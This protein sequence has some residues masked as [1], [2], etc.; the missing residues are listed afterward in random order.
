MKISAV[1]DIPSE[2]LLS[3]ILNTR[4]TIVRLKGI[5]TV[6]IINNVL[7]KDVPRPTHPPL[8]TD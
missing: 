4:P 5:V 7:D 6:L 3:L 2:R 8:L 1:T